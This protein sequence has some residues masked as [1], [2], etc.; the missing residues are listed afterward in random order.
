MLLYYFGQLYYSTAVVWLTTA[1]LAIAIFIAWYLTP[2]DREQRSAADLRRESYSVVPRLVIPTEAIR[3]T[4]A[5]PLR[6]KAGAALRMGPYLAPI[7][8]W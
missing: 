3:L 2:S 6:V 8:L 7:V 1:T 4:E 5:P